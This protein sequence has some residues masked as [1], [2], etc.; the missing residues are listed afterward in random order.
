M[1]TDEEVTESQLARLDELL[2]S[3]SNINNCQNT[4]ING[5]DEDMIES[6][7]NASKYAN[8]ENNLSLNINHIDSSYD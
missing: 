3:F 7:N 2:L 8:N 4:K 5:D 1:N 6:V